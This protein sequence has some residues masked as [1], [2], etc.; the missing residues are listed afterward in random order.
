MNWF[1]RVSEVSQAYGEAVILKKVNLSLDQG[2]IYTLQG[3][4][5]S[6]KTTLLGV[7]TGNL[8]RLCGKIEFAA[9]FDGFS[10][11]QH[12]QGLYLD[13]TLQENFSFFTALLDVESQ[14]I[15]DVVRLFYLE[16]LLNVPVHHLSAGE[17]ARGLL[18]LTVLRPA[19]VYLFDEPFNGLDGAATIQLQWLFEELKRQGKTVMIVTHLTSSVATM[20]DH[21]YWLDAGVLKEKT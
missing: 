15:D 10:L 3:P 19:S 16:G 12:N 6:G 5:G 14:L 11:Y 9:D 21:W 8:A 18:A 4:N 1:V 20:T 7:L 13:L 17:R 2:R